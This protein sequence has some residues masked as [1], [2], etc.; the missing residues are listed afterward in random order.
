MR[1]NSLTKQPAAEVEVA[2]SPLPRDQR[3]Q[4]IKEEKMSIE[5]VKKKNARKA[6]GL[7]WKIHFSVG[8]LVICFGIK[9]NGGRYVLLLMID[10]EL[11]FSNRALLPSVH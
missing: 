9:C 10:F 11:V 3:I 2:I 4:E 1:F 5:D 6:V 7:M 8:L